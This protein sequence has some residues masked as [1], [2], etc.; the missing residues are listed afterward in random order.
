MDRWAEIEKDLYKEAA[1]A[2]Y[3]QKFQAK[4]MK[5]QDAFEKS[6]M[7]YYSSSD[8]TLRNAKG[9]AKRL[10]KAVEKNYEKYVKG[11]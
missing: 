10:N 1:A 9:L 3:A 2:Q 8:G 11:F 7:S 6:C 5:E 4:L